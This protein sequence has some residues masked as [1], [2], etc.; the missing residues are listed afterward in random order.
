MILGKTHAHLVADG[1]QT[2]I[3]I[4]A[5]QS[6][7][8]TRKNRT[9]YVSH[10]RIPGAGDTVPIH[11]TA[12]TPPLGAFQVLAVAHQ[13]LADVT[14]KDAAAEGH[15]GLID[16]HDAWMRAH[17]TRWPPSMRCGHCGDFDIGNELCPTCGMLG[18]NGR[19]P[20]D[21]TDADV[22]ERWKSRHHTTVTWVLRVRPV[23]LPAE[24]RLLASY[25]DELYVAST[26]RA[27][28][29]E[30]QAVDADYQEHLVKDADERWAR[31][32]ARRAAH[33]RRLIQQNRQR[34]IELDGLGVDAGDLI[35]VLEA[36]ATHLRLLE[37]QARTGRHAA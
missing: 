24:I 29:G 34:A 10:Q 27:L 31:Q 22:L 26:A 4:P 16:H 35:A 9:T 13:I 25:S 33:V 14:T 8:R 19:L 30:P 11:R 2:Q 15:G 12:G 7:T 28:A 18:G 32:P 6:V 5:R 23:A 20:V 21:T 37:E 1:R 17:D 3:R 36:Q